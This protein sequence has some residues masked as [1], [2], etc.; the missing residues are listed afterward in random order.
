MLRNVRR[1]AKLDTRGLYIVFCAV[2]YLLHTGCKWRFLP[3]EFPK[4]YNVNAYWRKWGEPDQ[5]AL[6]V[7]IGRSKNQVGAARKKLARNACST[8]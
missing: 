7:L 8:H 2:P 1:S 6:S 5:H 3:P 4:W